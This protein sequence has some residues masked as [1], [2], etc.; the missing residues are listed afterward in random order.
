MSTLSQLTAMMKE[1]GDFFYLTMFII[2]LIGL[3][4]FFL[5][6]N[7]IKNALSS[8]FEDRIEK[9]RH[10]HILGEADGYY[11]PKK[12]Y[13]ETMS[14]IKEVEIF[15]CDNLPENKVK[16]YVSKCMDLKSTSQFLGYYGV[17][18]PI[19]RGM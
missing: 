10:L 16:E 1:E 12:V 9:H 14:K 17:R 13:E 18:S 7:S 8:E 15:G 4:I 3:T 11:V 2:G 19:K 5:I 6:M